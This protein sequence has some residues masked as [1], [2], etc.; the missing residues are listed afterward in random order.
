MAEG[1]SK[2]VRCQLRLDLLGGF[3][4][5]DGAGRE[6]A[7]GSRKA[8]ALLAFLALSPGKPQPREKL[9]SLLWS[10]RGEAQ[11]RSSLRQA[12]SELR[13][14]LPKTEPP[15]LRAERDS[16][17]LDA[18]AVESDAL[19]LERLVQGGTP[20][21]LSQAA[22][23]YQ[24]DFLEGLDVRD[25][26]FE[27]WR[28]EARERA[29]ERM[30][31]ALAQLLEQQ[32]GAQAIAT[33]RRLLLLDPLDE[34]T[35]R[36]LMRL[37]ADAGDRHLA[38]QQFQACRDMLRAQL[39]VEPGSATKDLHD[40]IIRTEGPPA[41]AGRELHEARLAIIPTVAVL[42]FENLSGDP[43]QEYFADGMTRDLITEFGR[44][45]TLRVVAATTIFSYKT[46]RVRVTDLHRE[47]N[48][49]Y[50]LEG[51]IRKANRRIRVTAQLTDAETGQQVWGDRFD[52]DL[53]D[54][55]EIQDA[56]T[57]RISSNLYQPLMNY[58][59]RKARQRSATSADA[60][61][62][63]L[64]A[65]HHVDQ[66]TPDGIKEARH[67]CQMALEIDSTFALVYEL[68]MWTHF[69]EAWNAW[70]ED[71]EPKL[72]AAQ[73]DI[74]RGVT[75][76]PKSQFLRGTLGFIEV[77]LGNE[78]H[79]LLE[80]KGAVASIPNDAIYHAL[81]GGA[82]SFAGRW[83]EALSVLDEAERL[84]PGYHVNALFRADAYFVAARPDDAVTS[85]Q[86][87]FLALPD[88]SYA[89][90]YLAACQCE[91]DDPAAAL[92]SVERIRATSPDM[93]QRYVKGLLRG[94]DPAIVDRLLT[95]LRKAGL[96][97]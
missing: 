76:D 51:S 28:R 2:P 71:P 59:S 21:E 38:L 90:L 30:R 58:G 75:L 82:L 66:P 50:V 55:F 85:Y 79:G 49:Q 80:L 8:Q 69:H 86:Q 97:E 47:L 56:I 22:A 20:D 95:S 61:D 18:A 53:G 32:G 19:I 10:D 72:L 93:T 73:R 87:F 65:Y 77:F 92:R 40:E 67:A 16:V 27:E 39:G 29:R 7:I 96:P 91:L 64:R 17:W 45:A 42:P 60:Y 4:A 83:E 26:A 34:E 24:G 46:R 48:V 74:A 63:Y 44:L 31:E 68:L 84:A 3:A 33:A 37:Y 23:L 52:G 15:L 54:L 12:L 5:R 1:R 62:L 94:R 6:V 11:A 14:A 35:H 25:A 57:R 81:Y 36:R 88:F 41:P 89:R 43:E 13:R 9:T 78:R 70:T